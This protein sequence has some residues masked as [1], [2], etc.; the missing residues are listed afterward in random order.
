MATHNPTHDQD[1]EKGAVEG[2]Q[3]AD[4]ANGNRNAPGLDENGQPA[5]EVA[6]SQDVLGA[7]EDGTE[8]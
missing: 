6:I 4:A 1:L 2:T 7:N 8:G 5:D 3:P